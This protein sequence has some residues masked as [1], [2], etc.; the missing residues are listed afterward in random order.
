MVHRS[1]AILVL[2]FFCAA[3]A[4]PLGRLARQ[5]NPTPPPL[6]ESLEPEAV[7]SG[8]FK[9]VEDYQT[10]LKNLTAEETR[11]MERVK[12]SGA[13]DK[14]RRIVSDWFVYRSAGA[15][16]EG[17]TEYRD[18]REVDGKPVR[19]QGERAM[20]L[21]TKAASR[22]VTQELEAINHESE[23]FDIGARYR[24]FTISQASG[25]ARHR[26]DFVIDSLGRD[27]LDGNDVIIVAYHRKEPNHADRRFLPKEFAATGTNL[28]GRLWLHPTTL[29]L[30][31][32]VWEI[33]VPSPALPE[34][35]VR[36]RV[37][38]TYAQSPYGILVPHQ[39]VFED[40]GWFS[41]P[42]GGVPRFDV[43]SRQTATFAAFKQFDVATSIEAP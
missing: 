25:M 39:L 20:R 7:L 38:K 11:V 24:A 14:R 10:T 15:G 43:Q 18:V 9:R 22:S 2:S 12:K 31:K 3:S 26:N 42:K 29:Q 23:R 37:E 27:H 13:L 35:L 21:V 36:T 16:T 32:E 40:R 17:I 8:F 34:P 30:V 4:A 41:H 6:G 19:K 28:R 33:V 1:V 5:G